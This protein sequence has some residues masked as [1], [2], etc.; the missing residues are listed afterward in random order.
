MRLNRASHAALRTVAEEFVRPIFEDPQAVAAGEI[1]GEVR[2]TLYGRL[3]EGI[4]WLHFR[5][6]NL[7]AHF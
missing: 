2:Q 6:R 7:T 1:Q 5:V 3:L 4:S